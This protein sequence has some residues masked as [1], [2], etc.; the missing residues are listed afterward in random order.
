M[1]A[2]RRSRAWK[3][4][5]GDVA[6]IRGGTLGRGDD[7]RSP[8]RPASPAQLPGRQAFERERMGAVR[9][10][11]QAP[12]GRGAG[13]DLGYSHRWAYGSGV[14]YEEIGKWVLTH[15]PP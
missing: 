5:G 12:G 15:C 11:R 3:R 10:E 7:G 9:V 4:S 6:H 1:P 8:E 14:I 2:V 13:A